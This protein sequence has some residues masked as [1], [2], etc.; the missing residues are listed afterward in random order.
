[1]IVFHR[2]SV[3][4]HLEGHEHVTQDHKTSHEHE[5][6]HKGIPSTSSCFINDS[7]SLF[8]PHQLIARTLTLYARDLQIHTRMDIFSV[9][10]VH[11][12]AFD[13]S[14]HPAPTNKNA[15]PRGDDKQYARYQRRTLGECAVSLI[16]L[17]RRQ[18]I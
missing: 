11:I 16:F 2:I 7:V 4:D 14:P 18:R 15:R 6:E 3:H 8:R 1:M 13:I 12:K 10:P 17:W 9:Y 5:E